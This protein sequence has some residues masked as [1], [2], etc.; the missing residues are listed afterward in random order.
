MTPRGGLLLSQENQMVI[1]PDD[2]L[3]RLMQAHLHRTNS[4]DT[5]NYATASSSYGEFATVEAA[6]QIAE[7]NR[8]IDPDY[9]EA[10]GDMLNDEPYHRQA[11]YLYSR[12]T[13]VMYHT[14]M[15]SELSLEL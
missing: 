13:V 3:L 4:R 5:H 15:T 11:F 8:L 6:K 7:T 2:N 9:H 10:L 12:D 1:P 14:K